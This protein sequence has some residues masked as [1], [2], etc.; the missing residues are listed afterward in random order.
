MR[1]YKL[2]ITCIMLSF[3]LF[4]TILNML[5]PDRRFSEAENRMLKKKPVFSWSSLMEGKFTK[6]YEEY[7]IDQFAFRDFWVSVKSEAERAL[8]KRDNNGVYLGKDGYLLQRFVSVNNE[9]LNKNIG[10]INRFADNN[11]EVTVYFLMV[12]NSVKVYEDKLPPFAVVYDQGEIIKKVKEN[13][14]HQVKFIDV[15]DTFSHHKHEYLYYKTDHHWTSFGAYYAYNRA[16]QIMGYKPLYLEDFNIKEVSNSFYGTLYSRGNYRFAKPDSIHFLTPKSPVSVRVEY[17]NAGRTSNSLYE[18]EY[19][20]K[21]DKYSVFLDGNHSLTV[22]KT[23]VNNGR[24]LLVVKDSYAHSFVP[25]LTNHYEE[26]HMIDLRL[27]TQRLGKYIEEN[28]ISEMLLLYNTAFFCEDN[29]I[30]G[31]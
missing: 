2:V 31:L 1:I 7:L 16:G 6:D 5:T 27:Y 17:K 13:L 11:P 12:P 10:A 23:D 18:L 21:K 24:K 25:Y 3:F 15:L 19:L 20:E 8:Q 14:R 9:R 26:I 22:I 4:M 30:L 28:Q 29:S